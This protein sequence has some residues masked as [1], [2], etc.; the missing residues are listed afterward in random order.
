MLAGADI[1]WNMQDGG[2]GFADDL[3]WL[4]A[5]KAARALIPQQDFAGKVLAYN[6]ILRGRFENVT[7]EVERLLRGAHD[8]AVEELSSHVTS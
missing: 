7:D 3:L 2:V 1:F 5:V 8:R 6:R 4:I